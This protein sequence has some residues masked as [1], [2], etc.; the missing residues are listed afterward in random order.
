MGLI[1]RVMPPPAA[2][3]YEQMIGAAL[4]HQ[5]SLGITASADCGVVL[6]LLEVYRSM[7]R[8]GAL[9][10]RVLVMP[11]RKVDGCLEPVPL[12]AKHVS[13]RLRIDTVKILADGGL[14]GATAA[15]SV[16]Y[17]HANTRGTLR[18]DKDELLQLCRES[19]DAGWRIATHAIGDLTI[20]M[21]L[22]IYDEL[23]P[24]SGNFSHRIE[25]FALPSREQ[26]WRAARIGVISVPQTIFI[27]SLGGN[28]LEMLP[29]QFIPRTYPV[30]AMLDAGLTV[31]LSSDAP[32]V[33]DDNPLAGMMAAITR[34]TQDGTPIA[35]EQAITAE[36]ALYGYTMGGALASG[37]ESIRG[38]I[39][40]GKWADVAVLSADPLATEPERLLEI[41]V[42]M[43]FVAGERVYER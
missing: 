13:D 25:H 1:N 19:H 40:A 27:R 41:Q 42:E 35:P 18:L 37:E 4:A 38:S 15:L 22:D 7:D 9:P 31:A 20:D 10:A 23:G 3:E 36:E 26:L 29:D 30:R 28:F 5:L 32:V 21:V 39:K 34:R 33:E 6:E 2:F 16:P 17:R 14:S 12:P 11:L 8:N 24:S 43:T